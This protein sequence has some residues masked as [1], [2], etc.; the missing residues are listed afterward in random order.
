[1]KNTNQ[2]RP[3]AGKAGSLAVDPIIDA[4]ARADTPS[5]SNA[6]ELLCVR[7]RISGFASRELRYLTPEMG[8]L[9]GY[10]VTA[11]V[12]STCPDVVG[13][14]DEKFL[15]LCSAIEATPHPSVVVMREVGTHPEFS[16]HCGEVMATAFKRVGAVGLVSD[17]AIRDLPEVQR[18][19]FRC[20][21]P[22][23]VASHGTFRVVRIQ[24]PVTVCGL[25]IQPRDLLHG[26]VNGLITV[27]E[28]KREEL[29][30]MLAKIQAREAP[31]LEYINGDEFTIDGLRDR[32]TH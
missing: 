22:G 9:C 23:L 27:P 8:V 2:E 5:L 21:A 29:P 13:G 10:A 19:G 6:I 15:D 28:Q 17:S 3:E 14:L 16:A 31:L 4:I 24:V 11:E 30:A 26:D 25:L 12:E 18:I 20:F 1:M 32:L 7:N